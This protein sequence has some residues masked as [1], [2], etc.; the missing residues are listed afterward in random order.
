ME[1]VI[2]INKYIEKIRIMK[3]LLINEGV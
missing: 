2:R 3:I 1:S